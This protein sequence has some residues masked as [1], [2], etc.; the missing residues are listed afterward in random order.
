MNTS[1]PLSR[2]YINKAG[3]EQP[4]ALTQQTAVVF[5]PLSELET[6][7]ISDLPFTNSTLPSGLLNCCQS[8]FIEVID[9]GKSRLLHSSFLSSKFKNSFTLSILKRCALAMD[10]VCGC[11]SLSCECCLMNPSRPTISYQKSLCPYS[12]CGR[13]DLVQRYEMPGAVNH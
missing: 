11:L 7:N 5:T 6:E 9:S 2:L 8:N 4:A 10:V 1:H 13:S 3:T 12:T